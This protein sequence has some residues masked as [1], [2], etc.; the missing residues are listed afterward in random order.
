M[1]SSCDDSGVF[2]YESYPPGL[3]ESLPAVEKVEELQTALKL[4]THVSLIMIDTS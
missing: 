2:C 3:F 4:S 1:T